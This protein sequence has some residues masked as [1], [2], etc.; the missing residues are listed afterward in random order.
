MKKIV[1]TPPKAEMVLLNHC[2]VIQTSSVVDEPDIK[3]FANDSNGLPTVG[4]K[5]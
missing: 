5:S 3:R 2:D 1:Y 4:W